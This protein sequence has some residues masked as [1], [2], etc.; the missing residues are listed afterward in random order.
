MGIEDEDEL[1]F[2][3]RDVSCSKL[4]MPFSY[5]KDTQWSQ[6]KQFHNET[7]DLKGLDDLEMKK[8]QDIN[9][10]LEDEFLAVCTEVDDDLNIYFRLWYD[11]PVQPVDEINKTITEALKDKD[12]LKPF[13]SRLLCKGA[14]CTAYFDYDKTWNRAEIIGKGNDQETGA[15]SIQVKFVDYGNTDTMLA[16]KISSEVFNL[17]IPK[18]AFHGKLHNSKPFSTEK[19]PLLRD[20]LHSIIVDKKSKICWKVMKTTI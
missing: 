5:P 9:K 17:D 8:Y 15:I 2:P 11:N 6:L 13:N 3:I 19:I 18:L 16:E 1:N 20:T 12:S 7:P 14:A 4:Q 10:I